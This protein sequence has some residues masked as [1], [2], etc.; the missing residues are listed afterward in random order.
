MYEPTSLLLPLLQLGLPCAAA[1]FVLKPLIFRLTQWERTR[2][3]RITAGILSLALVFGGILFW[4]H[5]PPV[6][7]PAEYRAAFTPEKRARA[8]EL[9]NM[10]GNLFFPV[11]IN[12]LEV[13]EDGAVTIQ[14]RCGFFGGVMTFQYDRPDG[15]TSMEQS[16]HSFCSLSDFLAGLFLLTVQLGLP[17][18]AALFVL[19]PLI[20]R[21]TRWERTRRRRVGVSVASLLLVFGS[22]GLW[23][24]HPPVLC[25]ETLQ[26]EFTQAQR[27]EARALGRYHG[28]I[29]YPLAVS[30]LDIQGEIVTIEIHYG[31][32][33]GT[34]VLSFGG[35]D[36]IDLVK[37]IH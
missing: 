8:V 24:T 13:R 23:I 4:A 2:R 16:P 5:H 7:C 26:A 1:L 25:P 14:T 34:E 3:R 33:G 22:L 36:G 10:D 31:F 19:T 20:F 15:L 27:A 29:F 21:L 6:S 35:P 18:A 30:V 37:K 11:K 28:G 17:C 12:V 9:S 32:L